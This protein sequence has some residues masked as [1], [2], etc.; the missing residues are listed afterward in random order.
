LL[1]KGVHFLWTSDTEVA[2]QTLKR[3]LITAPVLALPS[4]T[5]QFV[6]ETDACDVGIG[7]VLSQSGHPLAYV[8][9]ALGPRNK[10]LS[11]YEKEYLA[12][13]LA[14]Q[15][16]RPYLQAGEFIIR[17]DHKSL[18]HLA[19]QQVHTEWQQKVLTKLMGLQY[20][21]LY[22]KGILNGA[23]DALSRKPPDSSQLMTVTTVQPTWLAA[24]Q[25]SYD[26]DT[27][28]QNL[29]QKL[30]VAPLADENYTLDH[31]IL[32]YKGRILVGNDEQLQTRIISAFHDSPQGGH[33]GFPVT[34][35]R[36]LALFKWPTMKHMTREYVRSCRTCQQTKP[37]RIPPAGLLQPL[38]IPSAPWET[39]TMDFIDG[40]PPSRQYNY[41]LV[42]VDK[43]TKYAHF[44]PV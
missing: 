38:P 13:L 12:I 20:K 7:A 1:R 41:L 36:L 42:V 19:D 32:R 23:A 18:S 29:L 5:E 9:R 17:T 27:H 24:V 16:W 40:L 43:L 39:A 30:A 3:A 37:E 21:I 22:K 8:S 44:I 35:R 14:V 11:V 6:I 26:E 28:A 15:Q 25:A 10:G 2:F 34:Y 31:G 4:F 33:S